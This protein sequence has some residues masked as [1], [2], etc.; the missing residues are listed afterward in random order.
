[1][2]A[3]PKLRTAPPEPEIA[4]GEPV[5]VHIGDGP[6]WTS[7]E[8]PD[9]AEELLRRL[10]EAMAEGRSLALVPGHAELGPRQAADILNVDLPHIREL[11]REGKLP[12]VERPGN[13]PG[14][15]MDLLMAYKAEWTRERYRLLDELVRE[16]Q[17]LRWGYDLS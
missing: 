10:L 14:V 5:T 12:S 8:L 11:I 4:A 15:R 9:G 6:A 2:A 16:A 7:L 1:M 13:F 17:E 3:Q